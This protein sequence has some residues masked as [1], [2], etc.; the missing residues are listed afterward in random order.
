MSHID[1]RIVKMS[2]DNTNFESRITKTMDSLN[3]LNDVLSKT[4]NATSMTELSKSIKAVNAQL[5]A[6]NIDEIN[7]IADKQSSWQKLGNVFSSLGKGMSKVGNGIGQ[8]I[9]KL[10]IGDKIGKIAVSFS[11]ATAGSNGLNK[12]VEIVGNSF[13]ALGIIGATALANITNSTVEAG[14]KLLNSFTLEPL[15]TGFSEYETKM[16]AISTIMANTADEGATLEDVSKALNELNTYADDTIYNFAQMTENIGRFTAA[17]VTLDNSVASIKGLANLAALFGVDATRASSAMYQM[18]QA[19][20]AGKIQLMDWNSLV[21]AGMGGEMFQEALI[22]TSELMGTG[23]DA[24]I[25]KFGSFRESLTRGEWLTADVMIETLKQISGAYKESELR[26]QGYSATQAK[27]IVDMA[28]RANKAATEVRTIT[29]MLDAMKESVQSG[30]AISWEH[31]LGD[32]E[33]ATELL[34]KVK[35]AFEAIIEPSTT[36]RNSMLEFWNQNGGRDA[37]IAGLTNAFQGLGK[38]M[39]P[40][41]NAWNDIFPS[42]TGPKLVEL[43]NKF[44]DFSENLKISDSTAGKI[45]DTFKGIFSVFRTVG[46]AIWSV[47]KGLSPLTGVFS[48]LGNI[49]LTVTSGIGKFASGMAEAI[50]KSKVFDKISSGMQKTIDGIGNVFN[51]ISDAVSTL[52]SYLGSLNFGKAF[53]FIGKGFS[54]IVDMLSPVFSA[55]GKALGT[56][57]FNTITKAM[58]TG[59]FLNVLKTLKD[60]F[61]EV[62]DIGESAK[63]V[64]NS[65]K[66]IGKSIKETL[67]SVK[68]SL[69]A[70]QNDLQAKT[71]LKIAAAVGIL[72]GALLLLAT[73]DGKELATGLAGLAVIFAELTLAYIAMF[74]FTKGGSLFDGVSGK[75]YAMSISMLLLAAA[76]KVLSSIELDSM[77]TGLLGL[78]ALLGTMAVAIN[79]FD[80]KAGNLKKTSSSLIIFGVSLMSMALALKML[81]SIDAETL[82]AGLFAMFGVLTELALFLA[83][84]KFGDLSITNSVGILVL[85]AALLV[86]AEG[87]KQFGGIKT[88]SVIKGLAAIAAM[89][90]EMAVFNKFGG[91]GIKMAS[92][93]IGLSVM[94]IAIIALSKAMNSMGSMKWDTIGRGLASL[95]GSL[96]VIGAASKLISGIQ[97]GVF[98]VGLIVMGNAIKILA[99]ALKSLGGQS[100]EEIGKSL[101]SLAGAL[102]ILGVA[103]YAM[104]GCIAGAAAMLVMSAALALFIPQMVLLGQMD[105]SQVG[106]AL[107]ALAG[108]LTVVGVAGY[109]LIGAIPGL[110]GLGAAAALIGIGCMAAGV[111]L[112]AMGAGLTVI[113]G[114]IAGSGFIVVEFLRQ[115]INLLPQIGL[116]AGEAF[117]N[118]AGAIGNG[119]PQIVSGFTTLL[120]ALITAIGQN[121]PLIAKTGMDIVVAFAEELA[122][123]VPRIATAGVKLLTGL[124]NG[125]AQ[126][127]GPIITAGADVVVNFLNGISQELPR[128]IDAGIDLALS[129]IEGVAQGISD[130][131]DRLEA[132]IELCIDAMV[133]AAL[134]VLNGSIDGFV[135]GGTELV[136]GVIDGMSSLFTGLV[137]AGSSII[138][139]VEQGLGD[140][141][142]AL[143]SA[144]QDLIQGFADGIESC[145]TWVTDKARA[146]ANA[147]KNA[148]EAA[149]D[150]N[151]PS[152]VF[153]EIGKSTGEGLVLGM[154]KSTKIVSNSATR[155]ADNVIDNVRNPLSKL[156]DVINNNVDVNPTIRPVLDLSDVEHNSRRL[157]DLI[158]GS[159]ALSIATDNANL[160][161]KSIG[162]IQNGKDNSDVI[163]ALKDLKSSLADNKSTYNINGITYDDGSNITSAVETLVRAAKMERRI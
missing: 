65:F 38:V 58:Q 23:A 71:I 34:T 163:S 144:G 60:T 59:T 78:L 158:S 50:D 66:G 131:S 37:V 104:T 21:N 90:A 77:M 137:D 126:N 103:M 162:Q 152:K 101:V 64:F 161:T 41:G 139:S 33:Q 156:N 98:A 52:F 48:T 138:D 55:L 127:I 97:L 116:K 148:A 109:L 45:K 149:L 29:G 140:C 31:I 147:A 85:S 67:N 150:I 68:E 142:T 87:V 135:S 106:I 72:A 20:A 5:S 80:K 81:G 129:F 24:A 102:V 30:W 132:A 112:T 119:L 83:A 145:W 92:L 22:R 6:L 57:N 11:K 123:G 56:I 32:K 100:W 47:L 114:L 18:S 7:K 19:I 107:V 4:G 27:A 53:E 12:S 3:K 75:L 113:V 73:I 120:Q 36:A 96:L 26:A 54:S 110:L 46:E 61:K 17:G 13:S 130:N 99:E 108:A 9:D 74:K 117:V 40:I 94:S 128:I 133:D 8:A 143:Y 89:L 76:L 15:S 69:E 1:E 95:A 63:G 42:M 39:K 159:N 25:K 70:W 88:D 51:N 49:V 141:G 35:D 111:G 14:K 118:F 62:G 84:A 160:M 105:W 146:I 154:D 79:V 2:F 122:K 82:G 86:L 91:S 44:K 151:S 125:I 157:G 10:N 16:N 134:A 43:S 124:L 115:L 28:E 153:M 136:Q 155:L 93:A 121:I